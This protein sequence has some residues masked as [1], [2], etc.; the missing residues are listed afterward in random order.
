MFFCIGASTALYLRHIHVGFTC[1]VIV[2]CMVGRFVSV[3]GLSVPLNMHAQWKSRSVG[4]VAKVISKSQQIVLWCGGLRGAVA[5][6]LVLS[7]PS[8]WRPTLIG[9][10][11]WIVFATTLIGGAGTPPLLDYLGMARNGGADV[12]P[13]G[14]Q[15]V[16]EQ[17]RA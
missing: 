7:F 12:E 15:A 3:C 9:T 2:G 10:V 17:S 13:T 6:A 14:E 16:G 8:P 5:F 4:G 1:A 11:A